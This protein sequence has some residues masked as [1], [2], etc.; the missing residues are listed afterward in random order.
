MLLSVLLAFIQK[1]HSNGQSRSDGQKMKKIHV[2]K[3]L[4]PPLVSTELLLTLSI[5]IESD[6]KKYEG[7]HRVENLKYNHSA[8]THIMG[9]N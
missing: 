2:N 8:P 1:S 3:A 7:R 4:G 6:D 5:L 9:C